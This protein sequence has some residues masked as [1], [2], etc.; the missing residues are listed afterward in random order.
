MKPVKS[1]DKP[2]V[3]S[4]SNLPPKRP[5]L[6]RTTKTGSLPRLSNRNIKRD[7]DEDSSSSSP[8]ESSVS[9]LH[10]NPRSK[11]QTEKNP[12][13]DLNQL[14]AVYRN[15]KAE[16][17][18]KY[19]QMFYDGKGVDRDYAKA[20]N[21]YHRAADQNYPEA[22]F[23]L[24]VM[25]ANGIGVEKNL[26]RAFSWYSAAASQGHAKARTDYDTLYLS[27]EYSTKNL[28]PMIE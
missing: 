21:W 11:K 10:T 23:K 27:E 1:S 15:G 26:D 20:V 14:D 12:V 8:R 24:G 22:Q 25:Y 6:T 2:S 18:F 28:A 13:I 9:G 19:G 17:Q 7:S 4:T 5:A 16:D 3:I